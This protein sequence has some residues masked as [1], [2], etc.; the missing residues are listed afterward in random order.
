MEVTIGDHEP[1]R[2]GVLRLAIYEIRD[3]RHDLRSPLC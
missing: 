3:R 1:R 2:E